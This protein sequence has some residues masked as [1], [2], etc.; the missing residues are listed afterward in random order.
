[1]ANIKIKS[2]FHED[3]STWS[4]V[5]TDV[6]SLK[7]AIID[8]VLDYEQSSG[9]TFTESA[10]ELLAYIKDQQLDLDYILETHAHAD[11]LSAG[12]YLR[13]KTGAQIVIGKLI[14]QVQTT[15]AK[16]YNE[17]TDFLV[18]GSQFDVLLSAG[19]QLALGE[20]LI[21]VIDTP[22]HTP[23]CVSLLVNDTDVFIGDTLF[24]PDTGT[25]RCDFPGGDAGVL[26]DSIQRLF[27]LDDQ[28]NMHLCHDYPPEERKPVS[29]V[30]VAEQKA[31]NIHVRTGISR[32]E[33][34]RIRT[35]RDATLAKP[36]LILP[37]LQVNIRAG[38]LPKPEANGISYLKIPLNTL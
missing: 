25:A 7:T 9:H 27:A 3:T 32:E 10:D 37:S 5:I 16:L 35:E 8:P 18:N 28:V 31:N 11:H 1:M 21:Q 26:Y 20:S 17:P 15:F 2:F 14:T 36:R 34:I 38:A 29:V 19:E 24:M 4:H 6:A 23:A 13:T 12:D 33:F 22:G 30:T